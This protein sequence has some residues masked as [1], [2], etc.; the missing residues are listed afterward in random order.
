MIIG[1]D[2]RC[3]P[4]AGHPGAGIVHAAKELISTLIGLGYRH[5]WIVYACAGI[6][7]LRVNQDDVRIVLLNDVSSAT[8]RRAIQKVPCDIL[9]VPSGAVGLGMPVPCVPWVHDLSIY[10]HPEWFPQNI[11]RRVLTTNIFRRGVQH[12]RLITAVSDATRV[13][14]QKHFSIPESRIRVTHEGGDPVLASLVGEAMHHAKQRAKHRL[15]DSGITQ[16]FILCLGTVEPRKNIPM[17][18]SAWQ[19][20]KTQFEQ[21][22]DLVIAGS[23]G[24]KLKPITRALDRERQ[25][26]SEG[27]CRL[28]RVDAVSDD[29]KRDLLLAAEIVAVPSFHE[30]FGLVA[31]EGMQAGT[32][33]VAA[34]AGALPEVVGE[35]GVLL[36]PQD[37]RAWTRALVD[38]MNDEENRRHMAEQGKA[39]SQGMTWKRSAEIVLYALTDALS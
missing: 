16:P 30:G 36:P 22:T 19:H 10:E 17:L 34:D 25:Y 33:I 24:W 20:A 32:A 38:L 1:I 31:L 13:E 5:T 14:L 27:G 28:H 12:A 23:D 11:F 18:L 37:E 4:K 6:E 21:P 35:R 26:E 29:D 39:R 3:I 8:L 7:D 9:F 15:A 2:A